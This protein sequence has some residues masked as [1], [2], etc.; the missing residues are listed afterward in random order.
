MEYTATMKCP[1]G[2]LILNSDGNSLTKL[3]FSDADL[4]EQQSCLC[5]KN[6]MQELNAYFS[7]KLTSFSVPVRPSGTDFQIRVWSELMKIPY[8]E[9]I[10]YTKL[11]V[12]LGDKGAVRAV[13]A[14]NG[15]NP[16]ALLIP[17]HRVIGAGNKLTGYSGGIWRKQW[18]LAHEIIHNPIKNTLF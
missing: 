10:T 18:L 17:C 12:M 14:A 3:S 9:T 6:S 16:I 7:G 13:G 11:A 5:L 15:Q 2:F 4:Q 1:L 8:G